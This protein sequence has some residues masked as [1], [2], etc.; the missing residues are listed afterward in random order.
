MVVFVR[1]KLTSIWNN[2]RSGGSEVEKGRLENRVDLTGKR[3]R[4]AV[5]RNVSIA[6]LVVAAN[7]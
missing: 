4:P 6:T 2:C 5:Q 7:I 1:A 3:I